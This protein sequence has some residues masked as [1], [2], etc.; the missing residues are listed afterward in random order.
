MRYSAYMPGQRV[1]E[2]FG[3]REEAWAGWSY[4]LNEHRIKLQTALTYTWKDGI[5][6]PSRTY[7]QWGTFLQV[8]LGI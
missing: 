3:Q 5:A 8:E 1:E 6:D 2:I 7:G 4:Y